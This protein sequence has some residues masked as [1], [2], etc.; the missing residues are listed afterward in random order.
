M[1]LITEE[2]RPD[3]VIP[4]GAPNEIEMLKKRIDDLECKIVAL[5]R[6]IAKTGLITKEQFLQEISEMKKGKG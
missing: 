2:T 4:R 5:F 3:K 1:E 6:I